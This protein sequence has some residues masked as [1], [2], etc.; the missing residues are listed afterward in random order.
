MVAF[1]GSPGMCKS[2]HGASQVVDSRRWVDMLLMT[3]ASSSAVA[4]SIQSAV[5]FGAGNANCVPAS[6]HSSTSLCQ[7]CDKSFD[8]ALKVVD[9]IALEAAPLL[10]LS[11]PTEG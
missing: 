11:Y 7:D 2:A 9:R 6:A 3:A 8:D 5:G 4:R 1:W 10:G